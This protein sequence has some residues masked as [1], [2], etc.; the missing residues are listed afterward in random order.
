MT[1]LT[2]SLNEPIR[3]N[4][5]KDKDDWDKLL[6]VNVPWIISSLGKLSDVNPE[7][8]EVVIPTKSI[9]SG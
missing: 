1:E 7:P 2:M 4:S 8:A 5:G 9:S 6:L 3:N